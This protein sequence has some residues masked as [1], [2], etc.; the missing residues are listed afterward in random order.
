MEDSGELILYSAGT[1]FDDGDLM[2]DFMCWGT[3]PVM[4]R[5]VIAEVASRW[6]GDCAAAVPAGG[7]IHRVM[8]SDGLGPASYDTTAPPSRLSC[9]P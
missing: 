5:K 8:D 7:S 4:S 3:P 6:T 1:N 2:V 9:A